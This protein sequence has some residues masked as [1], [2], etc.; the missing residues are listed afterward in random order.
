MDQKRLPRWMSN[1]FDWGR[2]VKIIQDQILLKIWV[3]NYSV[4]FSIRKPAGT[5]TGIVYM[6]YVTWSQMP[7][8]SFLS[9]NLTQNR[10]PLVISSKGVKPQ[11]IITYF[12]FPRVQRSLT[13]WDRPSKCVDSV[14]CDIIQV[15]DSSGSTSQCFWA[16]SQCFALWSTSRIPD[17]RV[18]L[19]KPSN[20]IK[21]HYINIIKHQKVEYDSSSCQVNKRSLASGG[22]VCCPLGPGDLCLGRWRHRPLGGLPAVSWPDFIENGWI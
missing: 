8:G 2:W 22:D 13:K 4:H 19:V 7:D 18:W 17:S 16:T 10:W 6:A 12:W 14:T 3:K 9:W 1:S 5:A 21:H 11:G 15:L 20:T